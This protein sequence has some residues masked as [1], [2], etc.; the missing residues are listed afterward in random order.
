MSKLQDITRE[1]ITNTPAATADDNTVVRQSGN[2]FRN[3]R[4][5]LGSLCLKR[6]GLIWSVLAQAT[7]RRRDSRVDLSMLWH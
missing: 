6:S 5:V 4:K 2:R 3:G 1:P 7:D